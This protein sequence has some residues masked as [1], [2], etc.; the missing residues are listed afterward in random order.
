MAT[1]KPRGSVDLCRCVHVAEFALSGTSGN[2]NTIY[3]GRA[4]RK[5]SRRDGCEKQWCESTLQL[6]TLII[7]HYYKNVI[8]PYN[9]GLRFVNFLAANKGRKLEGRRKGPQPAHCYVFCAL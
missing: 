3:D 4:T 8:L 2:G 7:L 5:M 9:S 6:G 1:A